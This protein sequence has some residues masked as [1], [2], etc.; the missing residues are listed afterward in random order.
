[1]AK[2]LITIIGRGHSGTRAISK[3]L[4]ESGVFMGEN[5][6]VSGD[7]VPPDDLY[8]A[9]RVMA[10]KVRH[11]GGCQWD[12]SALHSG[13]IDPAFTRLVHSYL[14][15]V[16]SS[17]QERRGWKLPETTLV[18]PWIV[19]LYPE[20]H[21]I[22]WYRDPRD[23]ILRPHLTDDLSNFGIEWDQVEDPLMRRAVSWKYQAA[24]VRSTPAPVNVLRVRFEDFVL[25][26]EATL[27]ALEKYLG[28]PLARIAV[29]PEA[30]GRW[31]WS[32][33][34]PDLSFL[35]EEMRELGY[36][37]SSDPAGE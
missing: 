10:R 17:G 27:D 26:Q 29:D 8:E 4:S 15:S 13:P 21:Y 37:R 3:T 2:T 11:L 33:D 34:L 23:S 12:F 30:V 25:R 14:E 28:F 19:R 24:I 31:R 6:N 5:L 16:L 7:L 36:G 9:C 22:F 32:D 1:M 18:Y 35:K 20:I